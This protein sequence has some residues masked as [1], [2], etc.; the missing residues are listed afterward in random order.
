MDNLQIMRKFKKVARMWNEIEKMPHDFEGTTVYH[1]EVYML[2]NIARNPQISVTGLAKI[3]EITKGSVSEVVKKLEKKGFIIKAR[4]RD[5]ASKITLTVS[6]AGLQIL[7][8]HKKIHENSEVNFMRYNQTLS[9]EDTKVIVD[10]LIKFE[11]FLSEV[12]AKIK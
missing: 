7:E 6:P 11:S 5:N 4:A 3:L 10:F 9:K 8:Y 1:A 12:K 2:M